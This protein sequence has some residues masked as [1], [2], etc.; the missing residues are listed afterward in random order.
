MIC[1]LALNYCSTTLMKAAFTEPTAALR[2]LASLRQGP[3]HKS[4]SQKG[5]I[6]L[7]QWTIIIKFI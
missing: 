2:P 7:R 3:S 6:D 4:G 5:K 1:L